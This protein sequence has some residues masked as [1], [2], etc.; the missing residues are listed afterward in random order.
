MPSDRLRRGLAEIRAALQLG[1]P[2]AADERAK[3]LV[4]IEDRHQELR[5]DLVERERLWNESCAGAPPESIEL[6]LLT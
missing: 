1:E 5:H 2:N 3:L 4:A 6:A